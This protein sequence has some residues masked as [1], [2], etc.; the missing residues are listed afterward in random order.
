MAAIG[1]YSIGK[2]E[3]NLALDMIESQ[4]KRIRPYV[5]IASQWQRWNL[6][7]PDPLRRVIAMDIEKRIDG[8]WE[9]VEVIDEHHVSTLRRA[10]E[11]KIMR[12]MEKEK[13]EALRLAYIDDVCRRHEIPANTKMRMTKRWFVI[14]KNEEMQSAAW[15]NAW[16]PERKSD[17]LH[18]TTCPL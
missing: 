14:P 11:L 16:E 8:E 12:R 9:M 7:S 3:G 5:L 6:F 4:R 2:F 13:F 1:I 17:V 18:I 10:N 15:W